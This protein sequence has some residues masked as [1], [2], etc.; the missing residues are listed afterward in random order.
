MGRFKED[1]TTCFSGRCT[2]PGI[3]VR[4]EIDGVPVLYCEE[5]D[6][7]LAK[8]LVDFAQRLALEATSTAGKPN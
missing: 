7:K 5:C 8:A 6:G 2:N 1:P 4:G 3:Y